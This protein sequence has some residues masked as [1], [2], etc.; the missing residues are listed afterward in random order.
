MGAFKLTL[1][2]RIAEHIPGRFGSHSCRAEN[3]R[4]LTSA[5][6]TLEAT[7]EAL[8]SVAL[9]GPI[10]ALSRCDGD[11]SVSRRCIIEIRHS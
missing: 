11:L 2:Y 9:R 10:I 7:L 3:L 6:V 1:K 8:E 5:E 4:R